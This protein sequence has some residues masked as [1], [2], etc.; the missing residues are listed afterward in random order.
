MSMPNDYDNWIELLNQH[1]MREKG[2]LVQDING[3]QGTVQAWF[4]SGMSPEEAY[5][6]LKGAI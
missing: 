4:N 1:L 3:I 6:K 5:E 2:V